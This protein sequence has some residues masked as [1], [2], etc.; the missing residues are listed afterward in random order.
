MQALNNSLSIT[1]KSL[2][3]LAITCT[4][5]ALG[6]STAIA[7]DID[8][9]NLGQG[10]STVLNSGSTVAATNNTCA[11]GVA[12]CDATASVTFE[13]DNDGQGGELA[14]GWN[15]G[16]ICAAY[17]NTEFG[18]INNDNLR[19]ALDATGGDNDDFLNVCVAFDRVVKG[20][21]FDI[22]D[23][24]DAGWDDVVEVHYTSAPSTTPMLSRND[25]INASAFG[26]VSTGNDT[27]RVIAHSLDSASPNNEAQ[28]WGAVQPGGGNAANDDDGGNITMDFGDT[29]VWG[30]C[31][32][33]WAGPASDANPPFQWLGLSSLSW[34]STLPVNLDH[35][36]SQRNGNKLDIQWSTSSESFNV[37]FNIWGEV[38]GEWQALNRNF[39]RSKKMNSYS[40]LHYKQRIKLKKDRKSITQI[41]IS[42][43]DSRGTEEFYGP[44]DIG[45]SYGEITLPE[46]ID[47]EHAV[48]QKAIL[49][50]TKGFIKI[51]NRWVRP[52]NKFS[53]NEPG[54]ARADIIVSKQGMVRIRHKD[55]LKSGLDLR[56]V[57]PYEIAVSHQGKAIPRR[58][59]TGKRQRVFNESSYIDFYADT[60][61]GD[62]ALYNDQNVYQIS[63]N[64]ELVARIKNIGL[65]EGKTNSDLEPIKR[66]ISHEKDRQYVSSSKL[67]SPWVDQTIGYASS[68]SIDLEFD[69]PNDHVQGTDVTLRIDLIGGF[70]FKEIENDH[71]ININFNGISIHEHKWGGIDA[72][73]LEITVP[74]KY[75]QDGPNKITITAQN[76]TYGFALMYFDRYEV[77]YLSSP[78]TVGGTSEFAFNHNSE[79]T[80][81]TLI[82]NADSRIWIYGRDPLGNLVSISKNKVRVQNPEGGQSRGM[83]LPRLSAP[84]SNYMILTENTFVKPDAIELV[85]TNPLQLDDTDLYIIADSTFTGKA[86]NEYI[87]FKRSGSIRTTLVNYQELVEQ[88]GFGMNNPMVIRSF[89]Q[90]QNALG[91]NASVLIV[92]GHTYDYLNKTGLGSVSY[93]PTAYRKSNILQYSPTDTPLADLDGDGLADVAIGRWP[94]RTLEQLDIIIEKSTAWTNGEGVANDSSVVLISESDDRNSGVSFSQQLDELASR[95][96][97]QNTTYPGFWSSVER[98]YSKDYDSLAEQKND[99]ATSINNGNSL[100]IYNGHGSPTSW[101]YKKLL[102]V[103]SVNQLGQT[104]N[105][106]I[107]IP[108]ACYTTYYETIN[109]ESLANKLLFNPKGGAVMIAGA[110]TLGEYSNNGKMVDRLMKYQARDRASMGE[111]MKLAKRSL[112]SN[113]VE[114]SNLW[115]LLGDPT[116]RFNAHYR[117]AEGQASSSN[118]PVTSGLAPSISDENQAI[119]DH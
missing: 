105:P 86:L 35:F 62:L 16:A 2:I 65:R 108:L 5:Y 71:L 10:N 114:Q 51:N 64:N 113:K 57:G 19:F 6:I 104:A 21:T 23:V 102:D 7:V 46:P 31:M 107:F 61:R 27:N 98:Y 111:A 44:F 55:L 78:Y 119:G 59:I 70:D 50:K 118:T 56:G 26:D 33:Y 110:A 30:F 115:T 36:T 1:F 29:D 76:N 48:A 45:E 66:T 99:I 38:N 32:R 8:W 39:I 25:L 73:N 53:I 109:N 37:G 15:S 116:L 58:I 13:I 14:C 89:L 20:L 28:G 4:F 3:A 11:P 42:S 87:E 72:K 97:Q 52:R 22:L 101:S 67:G 100:T 75:V 12:N 68:Q 83:V 47:W 88:L 74:A 49:M 96:D 95:F 94:V 82:N 40:S 69:L 9:Q 63:I 90:K 117:V 91:K 106:S 18:G 54:V 77:D 60:V 85:Q 92:G 103:N 43:V 41:G 80:A 79:N 112:G 81:V 17:F 24:D 93:I 34:T 84:D